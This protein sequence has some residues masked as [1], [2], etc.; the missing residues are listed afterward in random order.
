MIG[1]IAATLLSLHAQLSSGAQT[2]K[3]QPRFTT[4]QIKFRFADDDVR[5]PWIYKS[6]QPWLS[7]EP[8]RIYPESTDV[9]DESLVVLYC[10]PP[11]ARDQSSFTA[12]FGPRSYV[13]AARPATATPGGSL[14][15]PSAYLVDQPRPDWVI[16]RSIEPHETKGGIGT[17]DVE[18]DNFGHVHPGASVTLMMHRPG[19]NSHCMTGGSR[20]VKVEIRFAKSGVLVSSGDAD[21][22]EMIVRQGTQTINTCTGAATSHIDLGTTGIL[23]EGPNRIRYRIDLS[24]RTDVTI[25]NS[26]LSSEDRMMIL[27]GILGGPVELSLIVGGERVFR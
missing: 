1:M 5:L 18:L 26:A 10:I 15:M 17:I 19:A 23:N 14:Q 27:A 21:F 25:P 16:V 13:I 22:G 2:T 12:H 8:H 6:L 20:I 9:V 3:C 4:L 7:V 11:D 24:K